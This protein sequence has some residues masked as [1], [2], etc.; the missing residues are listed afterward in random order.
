MFLRDR[1]ETAGAEVETMLRE[2]SA[3]LAILLVL[4]VAPLRAETPAASAP[5]DTLRLSLSQAI[6][7][8]L[9]PDGNARVQMAKEL[10]RQSKTRASQARAALLPNLDGSLSYQSRTQN[11]QAFGLLIRVPGILIPSFVGP[12]TVFDARASAT[13]SVFDLGSIRRYQ[14]SK[15]AVTAADA[16]RQSAEEQTRQQVSRA[17]LGVL[18]SQAVLQAERANAELA[19]RLLRLATEQKAAGTGTAIE[20]TRARVQASNQHQRLLVAENEDRRSRLQLLRAIGLDLNALVETAD[21]M[22]SLPPAPTTVEQ[23]LQTALLSRPDWIA[24]QRREEAARLSREAVTAERVPSV[25]VFGDY[26]SSGVDITDS[27]ATRS[28][29]FSVRIPVFDGGRRDARRAEYRSLWEQER[30]RTRDLKAQIEL[31]IRVALDAL[32][33]AAE[34]VKTAEEGLALA[35][36]ELAQAQRRY[37]AGMAPG[38]ELTDAQ[39]RLERARENRVT[40][41]YAYNIARIDQAA[42]TGTLKELVR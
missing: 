22:T 8:A 23:A 27:L 41:L 13:Q 36:N 38:I 16:E 24:Q 4:A 40:A 39:T 20:V 9:G 32:T 29:G 18:R 14:A 21:P 31:E 25:N 30:I 5:A 42:A 1:A 11:L 26:G 7:I 28:I 10:V 12:F 3:A 19:E 2:N 37:E 34:Q 17:Y 35:E 6:S 33:S 15:T